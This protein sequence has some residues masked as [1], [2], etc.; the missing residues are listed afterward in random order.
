MAKKVVHIVWG[1][2]LG[3]IETM[4][5]NIINEQVMHNIDITLI[6]I[7]DM[8]EDSL[9]DQ[10]DKRV[11]IVYLKR[12]PKSRNII[13]LIKLNAHLISINP[14]VIHC[15]ARS[16]SEFILPFLRKRSIVTIHTTKIRHH[17]HSIKKF[18]KVFAIS[19]SVEQELKNDYD[20]CSEIVYNG[21]DF[22]KIVPRT[23]FSRKERFNIVQVGRITEQK[24]HFVSIEAIKLLSDIN[25][26][27]DI[28]GN[29]ELK[30]ELETMVMKLGLQSRISF[31]GTKDQQYIF[32]H[33]K[34]YDLLLQPSVWEGFGLTVVEAMGANIPVAISLI[35]GMSE[36]IDNGVYGDYFEAHNSQQCAEVIR[37]I[38]NAEYDA[39]HFDKIY[40]H[41]RQHF[42]VKRTAIEYINAYANLTHQTFE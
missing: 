6:I 9:I 38:Y 26:H 22:S 2:R 1:F 16:L 12:K 24:G 28:I 29:G 7:N 13:P 35:D 42:N 10:I 5:V 19:K 34:D 41:A 4:L 27:L 15:H 11:N 36:I 39:A 8:I 21:I 37:K 23:D 14:D 18:A 33:L 25:I 3:G 30:E 31:L 20:I 17:I 32:S 40:S